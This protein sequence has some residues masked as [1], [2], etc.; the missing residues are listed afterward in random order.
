MY[1]SV[2]SLVLLLFIVE[3]V[4]PPNQGRTVSRQ[5]SVLTTDEMIKEYID[6]QEGEQMADDSRFQIDPP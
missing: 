1:I 5:G 4:H 6:E 2:W 3:L